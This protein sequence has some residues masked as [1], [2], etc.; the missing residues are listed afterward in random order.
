MTYKK[1]IQVIALII[2]PLVFLTYTSLWPKKIHPREIS[3]KQ[4]IELCLPEALRW[5]PDARLA[6]IISTE[7]GEYPE[8]GSHGKNG[9][10]SN[11]N[12]IFVE[13][14]TGRNLLV[15]V[16]EGRMSYTR[17]LLMAFKHPIDISA[18]KLDSTA[19]IK[20]LT[21]GKNPL[22]SKVHFELVN[23][24]SLVLR[25]Y[26]EYSGMDSRITSIDEATGD[27]ISHWD[28]TVD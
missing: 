17:E 22:P 2:L 18:L 12:V 27:V 4:A 13:K 16:R 9:L 14:N 1:S 26:H 5:S 6:Y 10:R 28:S 25:V 3:L 24:Q 19:A 21:T 23:Q 20:R 7:A 11:W 8:M 15:A